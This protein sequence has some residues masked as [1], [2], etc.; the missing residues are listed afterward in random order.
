MFDDDRY[1]DV[2]VEY[3]KRTPDDVQVRITVSNRGDEQ[4]T[5]HLL[6]TLWFRNTWWMGGAKGALHAVAG[7]ANGTAVIAADHPDLG[8]LELRCDGDPELLFTENE[9]NSERLWGT[10][11]ATPFVKDAFHRRTSSTDAPTR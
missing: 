9:T 3:A 8:Q 11:N 4:A 10:A 6:P 2:D 7:D 1:V 5:L